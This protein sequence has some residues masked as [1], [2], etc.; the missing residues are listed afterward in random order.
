ME[1]NLLS[2][3]FLASA[4]VGVAGVGV[5]LRKQRVGLARDNTDIAIQESNIQAQTAVANVIELMRSEVQRLNEV[6]THLS[7]QLVDYQASNIALSGELSTLRM[8]NAKLTNEVTELKNQLDQLAL[9]I[10]QFGDCRSCGKRVYDDGM[11]KP[12]VESGNRDA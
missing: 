11:P 2:G 6:N 5:W 9:M 8:Q 1:I 10:Q 4:A 7:K 3:E 12:H